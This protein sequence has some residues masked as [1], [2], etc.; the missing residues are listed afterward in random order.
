MN[1]DVE[2]EMNPP[3]AV[4]YFTGIKVGDRVH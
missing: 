3:R 2:E 1:Y 4:P